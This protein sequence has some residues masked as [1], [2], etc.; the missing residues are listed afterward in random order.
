[1]YETAISE[2]ESDNVALVNKV[3]ELED[4]LSKYRERGPNGLKTIPELIRAGELAIEEALSSEA[5]HGPCVSLHES[6]GVLHEEFIELRDEIFKGGSQPRVYALVE[7][8]SIQVAACA[9][10]MAVHA[11]RE[12]DKRTGETDEPKEYKKQT[13]VEVPVPVHEGSGSLYP[14]VHAR[15][16]EVCTV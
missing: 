13:P 1:M 16:Q 4:E 7:M 12:S 10:K 15:C 8:E 6:Y 14:C 11:R 3:C 9:L 2:L 5:K